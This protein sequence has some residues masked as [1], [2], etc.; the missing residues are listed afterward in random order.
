MAAVSITNN[1]WSITKQMF[2]DHHLGTIL[3]QDTVP[4]V[5]HTGMRCHNPCP[6]KAHAVRANNTSLDNENSTSSVLSV[7]GTEYSVTT[8]EGPASYA[9]AG[10]DAEQRDGAEKTFRAF[11]G[12]K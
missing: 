7:R 9:C 3:V 12:E 1:C 11:P 6:W 4:S 2:D 10:Q 5:R 8:W